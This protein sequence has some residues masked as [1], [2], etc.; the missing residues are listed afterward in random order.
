MEE[1]GDHVSRIHR[2]YSFSLLTPTHRY[3]SLTF[4]IG[5]VGLLVVT[6][7]YGYL[8]S[9]EIFLRLGLVLAA[10]VVT[11]LIDSRFIKNKEYSKALHMS[12]FG[13]VIWLILALLG[14]ASVSVFSKIEPSLFV[15][16]VGMFLFASF[17]IGLLT[18]V[19][20]L[21]IRKALVLCM[22][23]PLAMFLALIPQN[24]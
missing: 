22:L 4:S 13:N 21:T 5:L 17:R 8:Q 10:L 6:T 9:D 18:T 23:Q 7:V 15:I 2:R 14:L 3:Q 24:I 20:G 16:T 19:L 1:S 12:F 11:Q